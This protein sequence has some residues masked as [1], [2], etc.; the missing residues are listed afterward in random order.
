MMAS[1][2]LLSFA[3]IAQIVA[4]VVPAVPEMV[5]VSASGELKTVV[6][7]ANR[8]ADAQTSAFAGLIRTDRFAFNRGMNCSSEHGG[9]EMGSARGM[10]LKACQKSCVLDDGCTCINFEPSTGKCSKHQFC[11][12]EKCVPSALVDTYMVHTTL[13]LPNREKKAAPKRKPAEPRGSLSQESLATASS[14]V[15]QYGND[16]DWSAP[17]SPQN[18]YERSG[19]RD[20]SDGTNLTQIEY[21]HDDHNLS[22]TTCLTRCEDNNG[23]HCARYERY[24]QNEC[25]LYGAG[26]DQPNF[27]RRSGVYDMYVRFSGPGNAHGN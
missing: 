2:C 1:M 8:R 22:I 5:S 4:A 19:G 26:C 17:G 6:R 18:L 11:H 3:S 16:T 20:C 9:A 15:P 27:C 7:R 12:L 13:K 14:S 21:Y 23:C 24:Y 10:G 25:T